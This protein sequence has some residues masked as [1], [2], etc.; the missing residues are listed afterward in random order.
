VIEGNKQNAS[1]DYSW[2]GNFVMNELEQAEE[3][4]MKVML[5]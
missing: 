1:Y 4:Q 5:V 2:K 3:V